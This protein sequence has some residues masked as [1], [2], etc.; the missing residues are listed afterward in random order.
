MIELLGG[1]V[2]LVFG[3]VEFAV[4]IAVGAVK[5]VFGLLGGLFSLLFSLGW[6]LLAIVAIVFL[7]RRRKGSKDA[8]HVYEVADEDFVSFYEREESAPFAREE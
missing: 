2:E 8:G 6:V 1:L 3:C 4:G 7:V 5:L